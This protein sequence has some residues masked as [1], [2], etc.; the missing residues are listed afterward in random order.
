MSRRIQKNV[1]FIIS[2][3]AKDYFSNCSSFENERIHL[4]SNPHSMKVQNVLQLACA[5]AVS[6]NVFMQLTEA[7]NSTSVTIFTSY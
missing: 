2:A 7:K 1:S 6:L 4:L 3:Q 5:S